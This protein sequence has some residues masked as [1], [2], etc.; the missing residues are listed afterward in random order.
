MTSDDPVP[1][2]VFQALPT[3]GTGATMTMLAKWTGFQ[4]LTVRGAIY[5]LKLAGLVLHRK[6][7]RPKPGPC[8]TPWEWRRAT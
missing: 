1:R 2:A 7:Q 8:G 3:D 5:T 6:G 4:Y